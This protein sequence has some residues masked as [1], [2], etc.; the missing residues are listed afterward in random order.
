MHTLIKSLDNKKI[1]ALVFITLVVLGGWYA[2]KTRECI[3]QI[4]YVPPQDNEQTVRTLGEL[5][6]IRK[7]TDKGDY[8]LFRGGKF[9]T[10]QDAMSVCIWN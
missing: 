8:Y 6:G 7:I 9:Q 2:W 10:M 5:G 3:N 4:S 1:L